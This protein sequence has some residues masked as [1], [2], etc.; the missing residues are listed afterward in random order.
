MMPGG[1]GPA[2]RV[3]S[4][5]RF[6]TDGQHI[7]WRTWM[8]GWPWPNDCFLH[9]TTLNF[10]IIIYCSSNRGPTTQYI[11]FLARN[12]LRNIH[13]GGTS[14]RRAPGSGCKSLP[15][16]PSWFH[17]DCFSEETMGG[18]GPCRDTYSI[19]IITRG[20]ASSMVTDKPP[21][22]TVC[23]LESPGLVFVG[24]SGAELRK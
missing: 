24:S 20:N 10:F 3:P 8:A 12:G 14:T 5:V 9:I 11:I 23:R 22:L 17:F 21:G 18:Q 6:K 7:G 15:P 13:A 16:P 2:Q 19:I 1:G 4:R